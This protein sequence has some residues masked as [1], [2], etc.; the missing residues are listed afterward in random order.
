MKAQRSPVGVPYIFRGSA[1]SMRVC[2]HVGG[3]TQ[4]NPCTASALCDALASSEGS[5]A[6]YVV[7]N[8][9]ADHAT[10]K[11]IHTARAWMPSARSAG[12]LAEFV[13]WALERHGAA[14]AH[15]SGLSNGGIC[16][17]DFAVARPRLV[18]SITAFPG[19]SSEASAAALRRKVAALAA[20]GCRVHIA[21]GS[22]DSGFV[23]PAQELTQALVHARSGDAS[24][25]VLD[26]FDGWGHQ[27]HGDSDDARGDVRGV[28][29]APYPFYPARFVE[30]LGAHAAAT[31]ATVAS[32]AANFDGSGGEGGGDDVKCREPSCS[33]DSI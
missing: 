21:V 5:W 16:A 8:D 11:P 33:E 31:E 4:T 10:A 6:L 9:A 27:L 24:G 20:S 15:L 30:I 12:K 13:Q 32:E 25:A 23:R 3:N 22:R 28:D 29:G 18:A 26:V 17:I 2:V 1:H 19:K 14:R 7:L